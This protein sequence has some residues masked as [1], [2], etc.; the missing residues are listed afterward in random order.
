MASIKR[1]LL[2][3]ALLLALLAGWTV[4]H[5]RPGVRQT[6]HPL[7]R[8]LDCGKVKAFLEERT[9]V[10]KQLKA[11]GFPVPPQAVQDYLNALKVYEEVCREV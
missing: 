4:A 6:V 1:P 8:R 7:A 5:H 9:A 2:L 10:F 3:L 11:Q